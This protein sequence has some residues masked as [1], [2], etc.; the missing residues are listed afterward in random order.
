MTATTARL[1]AAEQGLRPINLQ[2]HLGGVAALMELCFGD[3]LDRQ[4]WGAVREMRSLANSGPLLWLIGSFS[5][6]WQ[7]GY[8]WLEGGQVVGN[9]S[10]QPAE[11]D[12]STWLIANVA[13]HPEHRRNGVGHSLTQAAIDLARSR[14]ATRVLLQVH[15]QNIGALQ[16]YEKLG[17][18]TF[19]TRTTW[20][21]VATAR[22]QPAP[23][24][25]IT[26]RPA[27]F[28]DWQTEYTLVA[29]VR[30]EGFNWTRP[31]RPADWQPTLWAALA[32]LFNART[33]RRWLALQ[34]ESGKLLGL[35]RL[36]TAYGSP[37]QLNLVIRPEWQAQLE[38]PLLTI[39]L[40]QLAGSTF[41]TRLDHPTGQAE[42]LLQEL[43]FRPLQTLVWM[44]KRI[45]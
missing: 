28:A 37:N 33:T 18:H 35:A 15:R 23:A 25:G 19:T 10:T 5:P 31:L 20:E 17:F 45:Q 2:R 34:P 11:Y 4:G 43:G 24:P 27:R 38:R 26:I 30:P 3:T 16:L 13:V 40:S 42:T 8:V 12:P 14:G 21:R 44:E 29:T 6:S 7:L 22:T 1:P 41:A 32:D 36:D 39:A 9:V